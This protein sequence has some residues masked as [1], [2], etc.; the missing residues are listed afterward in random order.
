MGIMF[1]QIMLFSYTIQ[2]TGDGS[3]GPVAMALSLAA[4][5]SL[6]YSVYGLLSGNKEALGWAVLATAGLLLTRAAVLYLDAGLL[7]GVT[8]N[9]AFAGIMIGIYLEKDKS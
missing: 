4:L 7:F 9:I 2:G 5:L 8:G 6:G 1:Y 3:T